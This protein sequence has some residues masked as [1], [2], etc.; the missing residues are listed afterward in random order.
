MHRLV[1]LLSIALVA[2]SLAG[3]AGMTLTP[4][5]RAERQLGVPEYVQVQTRRPPIGSTLR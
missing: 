3:C 5:Q 2:G 4:Q 1:S